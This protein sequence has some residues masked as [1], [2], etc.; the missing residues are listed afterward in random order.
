MRLLLLPGGS[1]TSLGL[2]YAYLGRKD[3]AIREGER[4]VELVSNDALLA[5]VYAKNLA[6]IYAL[7]GEPEAAIDQIEY[8]LAI[9]S[10]LT[11]GW[12]RVHPYWDPLRDHPRFQALLEK[13]D[14]R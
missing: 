13:Y 8:L 1:A 14:E 11:G 7:V 6:R 5:S 4:A 2:T 3:D 9:P 12:L 10:P